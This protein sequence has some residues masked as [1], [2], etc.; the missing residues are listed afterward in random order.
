MSV[1]VSIPSSSPR[2]IPPGMVT[3]VRIGV[4]S[5][6]VVAIGYSLVLIPNVEGVTFCI[7]MAGAVLGWRAG[8]AV[9][10]IGEGLFSMFNPWGPPG[11]LLL[12]AQMLGMAAAGG[13]AG[14]I[15]AA[16]SGKGLLTRFWWCV[17]GVLFSL[18]FD[19]LTTLTMPLLAGMEGISLAVIFAAQLPFS[20]VKVLCNLLLFGVAFVPMRERLLAVLSTSALRGAR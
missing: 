6:A 14:I 11:P 18:W 15:A 19:L 9:G 17:F 2:H 1:S 10:I 3:A 20:A 7:A 8:V 12:L 13:V 4:W 5:A 16:L